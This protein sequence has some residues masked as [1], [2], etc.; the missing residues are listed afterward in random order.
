MESDLLI[1]ENTT[2]RSTA[3]HRTAPHRTAPHRTAPHSTAP[4]STA[5]HSSSI[6]IKSLAVRSGF[7][8]PTNQHPRSTIDKTRPQTFAHLVNF[9]NKCLSCLIIIKSCYFDY[10]TNEPFNCSRCMISVS[11]CPRDLD[12]LRAQ[13][14]IGFILITHKSTR[15]EIRSHDQDMVHISISTLLARNA[16]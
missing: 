1:N 4:H 2:Q 5:Q 8:C 13:R 10:R 3:P 15:S 11:C 14:I 9:S 7:A 6:A 16:K 12:L